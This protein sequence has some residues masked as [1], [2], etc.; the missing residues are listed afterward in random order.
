MGV[1]RAAASRKKMRASFSLDFL[2]NQY[3]FEEKALAFMNEIFSISGAAV[4]FKDA[5]IH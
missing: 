3:L 4:D 5:A 1:A 2:R